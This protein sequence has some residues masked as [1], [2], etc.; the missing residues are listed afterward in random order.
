MVERMGIIMKNTMCMIAVA[1]LTASVSAQEF[2][3]SISSAAATI[4]TT[5]GS[6]VFTIDIIGDASVGTHMLGGSFSLVTGSSFVSDMTWIPAS[7]SAFNTDGGF[8]GGGDYNPVIFGQL[9]IPG[10]PPFDQ[11]AP[12][13]EIGSRIGSFQVMIEG[14]L[15]GVIDFQL[16]AQSPFTLEVLDLDTG[17]TFQSSDGNLTLNGASVFSVPSPASLAILGIGGLATLRR[18]R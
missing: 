11:P 10:V 12:G 15:C 7:W 2:S 6:A 3:L 18:R 9:V 13:S 5:G 4:D 14:Q 17:E 8:A 1:G 16:V